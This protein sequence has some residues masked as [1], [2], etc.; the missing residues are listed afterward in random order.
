MADGGQCKQ[1][2]Y[3][4]RRDG[5]PFALAG[6]WERWQNPDKTIDSCTLLTTVANR[7]V[8]PIHDR[9]PVLVDSSLLSAWL[10]PAHGIQ[11]PPTALSG[12]G[13]GGLSGGWT[14]Q[15]CPRR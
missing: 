11:P 10:N 8:Q 1:P 3:F 12:R 9:M 14:G 13:V 15:Q 7:V 5:Q 2:F 6:L 4:R